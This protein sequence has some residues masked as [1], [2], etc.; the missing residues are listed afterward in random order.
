MTKRYKPKNERRDDILR[1]ACGIAERGN[2]KNIR[3]DD[4]VFSCKTSAGNITRI[5]GG[6]DSLRNYL[7]E[8][9]ILNNRSVVVGQAIVDRHPLTLNIPTIDKQLYISQ[10]NL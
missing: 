6:M 3:R 7:I 4:L 2:Y 9:A 10:L 8:Y 5:F 1:I